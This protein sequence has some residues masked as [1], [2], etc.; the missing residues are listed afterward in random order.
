[1]YLYASTCVYF[2]RFLT[3]SDCVA[4]KVGITL[5]SKD[6]IDAFANQA[7]FEFKSLESK[8]LSAVSYLNLNTQNM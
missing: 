6:W 4:K 2:D 8:L 1:M 3:G 7:S 5:R